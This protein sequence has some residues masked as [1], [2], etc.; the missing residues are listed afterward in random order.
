M[1]PKSGM[2]SRTRFMNFCCHSR[3]PAEVKNL[4]RPSNGVLW[5]IQN[6][7]KVFLLSMIGAVH[8]STLKEHKVIFGLFAMKCRLGSAS[9]MSDSGQGVEPSVFLVGVVQRSDS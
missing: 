6:A 7:P 4:W 9:L 2:V 1:L 3:V 8:E 5:C